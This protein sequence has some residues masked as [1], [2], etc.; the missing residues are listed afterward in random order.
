MTG[1]LRSSFSAGTA[2]RQLRPSRYRP[3]LLRPEAWR[4]SGGIGTLTLERTS[5]RAPLSYSAVY[6]LA[7]DLVQLDWGRHSGDRC[8]KECFIWECLTSYLAVDNAR[9]STAISLIDMNKD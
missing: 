3:H 1:K 4:P 6:T 9:K 7:A 8:A 5:V 2:I